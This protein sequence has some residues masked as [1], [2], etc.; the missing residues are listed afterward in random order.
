MRRSKRCKAA[1]RPLTSDVRGSERSCQPRPAAGIL[2]GVS[3]TGL[4]RL[5]AAV[6]LEGGQRIVLPEGGQRIV[7]PEGGQRIVLPEGGQRNT[8]PERGQRSSDLDPRTIARTLP[9][10]V[11]P[12]VVLATVVLL[13]VAL[14][15]SGAGAPSGAGASAGAEA[16]SPQPIE[17]SPE[18]RRAREAAFEFVRGKL[19]A[20]DGAFEKAMKAYQ[21]ALELDDADAYSRIEV[22]RFHSYLSQIARSAAKRLE[23]LEGAAG[24]AGEA[25]RLAP[26]NLEILR[27]YA[28]VHLRLGEHQLAALSRAQEAYEELRSKTEGDLQVL[29]SLGQIYLWQQQGEQAAEVLEE[30][31]SFRPGHRMIQTMLL[32]ALLGAGRELEAEGV[33]EQLIEIEPASFE[34]RFRLAELRSER[35]DHRAAAEGLSSAP[36]EL[37]ADP[38]LKQILAQ[39]L[40]LSGANEQALALTDAL[41]SELPSSSGMHRLRVAILVSLTR[42]DEAIVEIKAL[43]ESESSSDRT[44]EPGSDRAVQDTLHLSRLLERVGRPEDAAKVL[45]LRMDEAGDPDRLQWTLGLIGVLERQDLVGEAVE[46]LNREIAG[47]DD[48]LPILSRALSELLGRSQRTDEA[49][50]VLD[51]AI[52]RLR[53]GGRSDAVEDLE[54][55]RAVLLAAAEDW[56]R[57]SREAPSLVARSSPE[58]RTAAQALYV[59][60]L[61]NQG[62][63]DEALEILSSE[64]SEAGA[65]RRLARRVELLREHDRD[66]EAEELLRALVAGG[67][68]DDLF[69]AAQVY[70]RLELFADSIPLLERLL[71]EQ[72]E[73]TQALFLLGAARE[74]LGDREQAVATFRRLLELAPDHAPTLNYLGYMWAEQGENLAE[75]VAMILRAVALDP[76]NGA[77]VD[78]LGWAYFR[79]GRYD[80]ARGHLEWAIRLVPDDA[81]ILEHLGDLY[82]ALK[83]VERARASYQQALDLG[84]DDDL[85]GEGIEQLRRKLKTLDEKGL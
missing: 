55:R 45:R 24:Y 7:L 10:S 44:S 76:D 78:S 60:A 6:P 29:T 40:H 85:G 81:T 67:D 12:A 28:D 70:Q 13:T 57:L 75:A 83:D 27:S 38:R 37:L 36:A 74:R 54:L 56:S 41:R 14:P 63:L 4:K 48:H 31:A 16:A 52:A 62:R 21:R 42:Y 47:A 43:L 2:P 18:F 20:E 49:L 53:A 58:N 15:T 8:F 79:L 34:Y 22:A 33:L 84:G 66:S 61:A 11:L 50:E 72:G 51:A 26:E 23:Y 69:F 35:G 32:E 82:L 46:I 64:S 9:A 80:E 17:E 71:K 1:S 39:E 73:S 5:R 59:E 25:R 30:A 77:Y 3:E 68:R 19:L 65:Q